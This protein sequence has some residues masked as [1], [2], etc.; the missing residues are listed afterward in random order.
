MKSRSRNI[1]MPSEAKLLEW[2]YTMII[3]LISAIIGRMGLKA[4]LITLATLAIAFAIIT[5]FAAPATFSWIFY[6]KIIFYWPYVLIIL[7]TLI[8]ISIPIISLIQNNDYS[9][10]GIVVVLGVIAVDIVLMSGVSKLTSYF[11]YTNVAKF[12]ERSAPL[13]TH[14]DQV[15]YTPRINAY[16]EIE[17]SISAA[18]ETVHFDDTVPFIS[19]DGFSFAVQI[20]PDDSLIPY[21]G[22]M[23]PNPGYVVYHDDEN[24]SGPRVERVEDPLKYGLRKAWFLDAWWQ[25]YQEDRFS[26][27][28]DPH[29]LE[30]RNE[31]DSK[32]YLTVFPQIKHRYWRLPYWAGVAVVD[33]A[34]NVELLSTKEALADKRFKAEWI[35]PMGL[36]RRYVEDQTMQAGFWANWIGFNSPGR[37]D[38]PE[39]ETVSGYANQYPFLTVAEDGTPYGYVTT[40]PV[41]GGD[42]L[43]AIYYMNLATG[44]RTKFRIPQGEIVYGV[45]AVKARVTSISEG[46]TW[47]REGKDGG[48]G[49]HIATEPV[50]IVRPTEPEHIYWKVTVT[51][52]DFKGISAQVVFDGFDP[53]RFETFNSSD[54]GRKDFYSW[55]K[56]NVQAGNNLHA[57][58][59]HHL[60]EA[61]RHQSEAQKIAAQLSDLK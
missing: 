11:T 35:A 47:Y 16:N 60:Q 59:L 29:Y 6:Q 22:F 58:L 49:Q 53:A 23:T 19:D 5:F 26:I 24:H 50:M 36:L 12:E 30:V 3:R 10:R 34:G 38:V 44:E 8:I 42:G 14:V 54:E 13:V 45:S 57:Q 21:N 18:P 17:Q 61:A 46:F 33:S 48:S 56:G 41:G 40:K 55:I 27:F 43:Y 1:D 7:I 25:V 2:I 20:T 9:W 32:E 52:T 31:D 39:F 15:R 4:F 51:N 37:L 28:E